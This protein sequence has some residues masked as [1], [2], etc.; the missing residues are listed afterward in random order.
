MDR[1]TDGRTDRQTDGRT[2]GRTDGQTDRRM[3]GRTDGRKNELTNLLI[4][5]KTYQ[6]WQ[7]KLTADLGLTVNVTLYSSC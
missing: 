7:G 3:D 6:D 5:Y 1:Q 4:S 2:D